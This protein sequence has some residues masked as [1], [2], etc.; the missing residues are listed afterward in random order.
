M[1]RRRV[2]HGKPI[3][4]MYLGKRVGEVFYGNNLEAANG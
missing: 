2:A 1:N 3:T 4:D